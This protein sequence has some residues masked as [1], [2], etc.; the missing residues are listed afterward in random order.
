MKRIITAT[1]AIIAALSCMTIALPASDA[2]EQQK[3]R[4]SYKISAENS[5]YTQQQLIDIGDVRGH[6]VR[7]FEIYRTYPG[8][9]PVINGVKL[10]ETWNRGMSDYID[11]NGPN[12]GYAIFV[13]QNDDRFFAR[14]TG[15][16]HSTGSGKLTT[17][18]AGTIT[19]GTGKLVGIQGMIRSTG[20]A[21]PKAGL[22]ETQYEIEYWLGH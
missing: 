21:E 20:T 19:G 18:I 14:T 6:Q 1:L 17:V 8:D 4:V 5:K 22:V 12:M 7:I 13:L 11:G 16:A 2:A 3:Q 9:A 15:H 10:K